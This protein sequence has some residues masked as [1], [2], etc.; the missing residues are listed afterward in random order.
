M[1]LKTLVAAVAALLLVAGNAAAQTDAGTAA[2][3]AAPGA[4]APSK[5]K[6]SKGK[7]TKDTAA[8]DAGTAAAPAAPAKTSKKGKRGKKAAEPAPVAPAPTV[9]DETRKALEAAQP[10][11]APAPAAAKPAEPQVPNG[12]EDN[13]PPSI[14]HTAVAKAMK[15]KPLTVTARVTDP[16]GVFGPILY[17]RKKGMGTGDYIPIKMVGSKL[18]QGDY[19]IEIPAQLMTVDALEYYIEAYDNAGNGPSRSGAPENP[20]TI[21]VEE[22]KKQVIVAPK[23]NEPVAPQPTVTVKPKG[24]PPSISHTA[25]TQATKGHPIELNARLIGETGVQGATVMFRKVGEHDFKALPMGNIGGDDYT[26][27]IPASM[28]TGDLEYY[29][30]AFDKYGNGPGRN[31]DPK[32]PYVV[33]VLEPVQP[34]MTVIHSGKSD[35][36]AGNTVRLV[37]AP[38]KPN[39][40]R[41][42]GWVFMAGFV[43]ATI[44]AG[45]EA[46]GAWQENAAYTHTF[47]YEGRNETQLLDKANAYGK[48]AK[49]ALIVGGASLVTSIV[50][51]IVFPDHPDTIQVGGSGGDVGLSVKF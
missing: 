51:L 27:T 50:L 31:G 18:T 11:P 42:I 7:A 13:D 14:T 46:L 16:S 6:P 36:G 5:K 33:K 35:G 3:P 45:G 4:A 39:P 43:G 20:F 40:G 47:E 49:T 9:D 23:V 28:A 44:F 24:A 48:R 25:T 26:A 29:L 17:L 34:G 30:E 21:K 32:A 2:A 19:T 10:A 38:F 15:G 8:P 41:T 1:H 37:K 12:P 22:E